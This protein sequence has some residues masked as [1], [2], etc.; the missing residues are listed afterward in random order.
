M[1][2]PA[3]FHHSNVSELFVSHLDL[4]KPLMHRLDRRVVLHTHDH[5]DARVHDATN[6]ETIL[7]AI[8]GV[9]VLSAKHH[10]GP[11]AH[12]QILLPMA[13]EDQRAMFEEARALG[14][15]TLVMPYHSCYKQHLKMELQ[16]P[17]RVEHYLTI[18][19]SS[20]GIEVEETYKQLRLLDD[21]DKTVQALKP[22]FS[23]LGYTAE[24][25]RPLVEW[26]IYC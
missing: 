11:G 5:N 3:P 6:I 24:Q 21:V 4:L 9:E 15:D 1:P 12:C 25:I 19:G 13:A 23:P 8:P 14:A 16:Y 7:R 17:V 26:A 20:L 18:L 22:R 2:N 10:R